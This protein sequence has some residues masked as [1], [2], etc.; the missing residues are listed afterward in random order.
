MCDLQSCSVRWDGKRMP[1]A[2]VGTQGAGVYGQHRPTAY[3]LYCRLC[4]C[5]CDF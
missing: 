5:V 2:I 4:M 1:R 3:L